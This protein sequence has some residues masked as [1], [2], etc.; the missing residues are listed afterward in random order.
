MTAYR[1]E[2][3]DYLSLSD[4]LR[5]LDSWP[6]HLGNEH[7]LVNGQDVFDLLVHRGLL[8]LPAPTNHP[9]EEHR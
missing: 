1:P 5:S 6:D 7:V 4:A 8:K 9:H 2:R 3:D